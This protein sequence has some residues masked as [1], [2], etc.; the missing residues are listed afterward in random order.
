MLGELLCR[1]TRLVGFSMKQGL[2]LR[3]T[4]QP[5]SKLLAF[6]LIARVSRL[7][8]GLQFLFGKLVSY[9]YL[10]N[11]YF[12]AYL[13]KPCSRQ[14]TGYFLYLD[15]HQQRFL[16]TSPPSSCCQQDLS[17][18]S[19]SLLPYRALLQ[20]APLLLASAMCPWSARYARNP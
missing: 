5:S 15:R 4:Q 10:I 11:K 14:R 1:A 17:L 7:L 19:I 8:S 9:T 6:E 13:L 16:T 2:N 18:C 3:I 20:A 12:K